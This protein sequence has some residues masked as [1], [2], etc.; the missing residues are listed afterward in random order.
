M[1]KTQSALLE[2]MAEGQV[3][4]D[5]A[6]R[7]VPQ[8]FLLLATENPIEFEGTFPLPEAQLVSLLPAHDARLSGARRGAAHR[9]GAAIRRT[10]IQLLEPVLDV[11]DVHE[12]RVA[13]QSVYV[14]DLLRRW[15]VTLVRSTRELEAAAI[16]S[17][18][19]GSLAL[20]SAAAGA[21]A[22]SDVRRPRRRRASLHAGRD[23]P[24]RLRPSFLAE[25]RRVGWPAA[26][27]QLQ[28][29]CLASAPP[30]GK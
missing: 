28:E 19:R 6:T 8:P 22:G 3:T 20:E 1:P 21:P 5:G 17:S 12:L 29:D 2:A 16:G 30:P 9:R 26:A 15:I 4:V 18:V 27:A 11:T 25:V 23:A 13:A 10:S 24:Y 14:D 7:P